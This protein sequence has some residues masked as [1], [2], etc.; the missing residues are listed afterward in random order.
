[1]LVT[2]E[3]ATARDGVNGVVLLGSAIGVEQSSDAAILPRLGLALLAY[4]L[5]DCRA[6]ALRARRSG[7]FLWEKPIARGRPA[8]F[9][10]CCFAFAPPKSPPTCGCW[11]RRARRLS[12]SPRNVS[13][14]L[15]RFQAAIRSAD[16][17]DA[18]AA[19]ESYGGDL[20]AGLTAHG[21]GLKSW[22]A[23]ERA[24]LRAEFL[25]ALTPYIEAQ[26]DGPV[27]EAAI[28]AA[29]R[30][31]E[32]DPRQ[33]IAY[34]VL[35]QAYQER[36][37]ASRAD[38]YRRQRDH[39]HEI[40]A[41]RLAG[42]GRGAPRS[43]ARRD[44]ARLPNAGRSWR[45]GAALGFAQRRAAPRDRFA[46]CAELRARGRSRAGRRIGRRHRHPLGADPDA[47]RARGRRA[48]RN[49]AAEGGRLPRRGSP[50][51]R[52]EPRHSVAPAD[53]AGASDSL[54]RVVRRPEPVFRARADHAERDSASY[55]GSRDLAAGRRRRV[56]RRLSLH[57]RGAAAAQRHRP[58]VDPARAPP[59]EVG[60]GRSR[61][62]FVPTIAALARSHVMEWLVR[63]PFEVAPLEFAEQFAKQAIAVSPDD[64]RGYHELGLVRV[65][66]RR[67][68]DGIECL[69]RAAS[70]CPEDKGVRADLADALV[71]NGQAREAIAMLD[72]TVHSFDPGDDYI[73]WVLAGAHFAREDYAATLLQIKQMSNPAP[74]FRLSAAA[75]ALIGDVAGARR[76]MKASMDFNPNFDL[77]EV[78]G[79][80]AVPPRGF[81]MGRHFRRAD[82]PRR[83]AGV[84]AREQALSR[85]DDEPATRG[86]ARRRRN[87][88]AP[89]VRR[90]RPGQVFGSL[91]KSAAIRSA[92]SPAGINGR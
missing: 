85:N 17:L 45:R 65:Y 6:G 31:L 25:T 42:A 54:G 43:N 68:D 64:H 21:E 12:L 48:G 75:R 18:A 24:T 90:A 46:A 59:A 14:D 3:T 8:T 53:P 81:A 52:A 23:R 29:K 66:R 89:R 58:A 30:I 61:P 16:G 87:P 92:S 36:G 4:L 62:D 11:R 56:A 69:N 91:A 1:V 2:D 27:E 50:R 26:A 10:N 72:E 49:Q 40:R 60:A 57:P 38:Q 35:I 80:G 55:R 5:L 15:R 47:D 74:A 19:C 34:R 20:L 83:R 44:R 86:Q 73:R 70:L 77:R 9:A 71:F 41:E 67:L 13:I 63:A 7:A 32:I 33:E 28:V 51:P 88:I 78:D 76:V 39:V 84:E 37:D 22:L 79:D 82:D